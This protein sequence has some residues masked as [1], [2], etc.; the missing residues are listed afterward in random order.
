MEVAGI[1]SKPE[2]L[3][4][5]SH[6]APPPITPKRFATWFFAAEPGGHDV[7]IDGGEIQGHEWLRPAHALERHAAGEIDLAPPT[8]INLHQLSLYDNDLVQPRVRPFH[9]QPQPPIT[10]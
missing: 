1:P 6:W 7:T 3:V 8:W 4:W 5:F 9:K 10:H 2:D